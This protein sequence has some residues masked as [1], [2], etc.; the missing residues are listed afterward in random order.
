MT[1]WGRADAAI[2]LIPRDRTCTVD[3][4]AK[5]VPT[6]AGELLARLVA[7]SEQRSLERVIDW[8]RKAAEFSCIRQR[9]S[10]S[11]GATPDWCLRSWRS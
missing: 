2:A 11:A 4:L 10:C 7:R 6:T 5:L 9:S 3:E 8:D 1:D